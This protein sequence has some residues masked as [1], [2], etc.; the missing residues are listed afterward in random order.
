LN[1]LTITIQKQMIQ[2][3]DQIRKN[4]DEFNNMKQKIQAMTKKD[5]GSLLVRDFTDE[6]Y[7]SNL[8]KDIFVESKESESFQNLLIV[9]NVEKM[10]AFQA[11]IPEMM[12]NYY[13]NVDLADKKRAR[14]QAKNKFNEVMVMHK[15]Y[16]NC[17]KMI[18]ED[19]K[20]QAEAT[21]AAEANGEEYKKAPA[22]YEEEKKNKDQLERLQDN[23]DY[24]TQLSD[25]KMRINRD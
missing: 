15:K 25:S 14:E 20:L 8:S 21:A 24:F 6:I 17:Q 16:Q 11:N 10:A 9:V 5:Q 3:D 13:T 23:E 18:K 12:T 19:E 7:K 1:E 22:K 2:K 4:M